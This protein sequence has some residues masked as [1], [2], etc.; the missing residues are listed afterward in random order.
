[1]SLA[2]VPAVLILVG[3]VA[4]VVLGGADFGAGLWQLT[5]DASTREHAYRAMAPVWE[6]NHVWLIF[7]LVVCWTCYPVAF[8]SIASTLAVPFFVAA[9]GIILRGTT[10]AMRS[11]PAPVPA[12]QLIEKVIAISSAL[13]PFALG[14]A[15]GGI[16]SGRVPVGNARGNLVTSWLNPTSVVI[17]AL[18]V[19]C[20]AYLAAVYLSADAVRIGDQ[21]IARSY[22]ARALASGVLAGGIAF[23]GLLVLRFD[24][25]DI[26]DG[27]TDGMNGSTLIISGAAGI[28]TLLLTLRWRFGPARVTA[29]LAVAFVVIGWAL[30]QRPRLIAG[31]TI[32]QAAAPRS[33]LIALLVGCAL[34]GLV[35][36]P[37]LGLLFVLVLRGRFDPGTS[38]PTVV[39]GGRVRGIDITRPPGWIVFALLVAGSTLVVFADTAWAQGVGVAALFTFIATGTVLVAE[40]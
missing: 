17:G 31:L 9:V 18:A 37:S 8:A 38:T 36:L 7:V 34:G 11:G 1:M 19:A 28:G 27:L 4:Y 13:T 39:T 10:Y 32:E 16:A 3:L 26:W 15:V 5:R 14:A 33:T 20:A 12:R 2:D 30:A 25:P 24:A 29:A 23:V 6:A 21:E 35:V 40:P 22:R